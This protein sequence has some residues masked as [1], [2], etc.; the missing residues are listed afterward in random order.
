MDPA[1]RIVASLL[2]PLRSPDGRGIILGPDQALGY[3]AT[4]GLSL[5][6]YR[7][8]SAIA[9]GG[10]NGGSVGSS[11]SSSRRDDKEHCDDDGIRH[12]GTD[13][14]A[15]S[16][17]SLPTFLL[18]FIRAALFRKIQDGDA[19]HRAAYGNNNQNATTSSTSGNGKG[20]KQQQDAGPEMQHRGSCHCGS[21]RFTLCAPR[22]ISAL[23]CGGKIRY[24]HYP[25]TAD[26][27]QLTKGSRHLKMYYVTVNN[28]S[29]DG[30]PTGTTCMAAHTFCGRCGVNLLRAPDSNMDALEVN[31]GCLDKDGYTNVNVDYY[32][33]DDKVGLGAGAPLPHQ[34][35]VDECDEPKPATYCDG[36]EDCTTLDGTHGPIHVDDISTFWPTE[37]DSSSPSGGP[38]IETVDS[39]HN[40]MTPTNI[41]TDHHG[42]M[43]PKGHRGNKGGGLGGGSSALDTPSTSA[44]TMSDVVAPLPPRVVLSHSLQ[45]DMMDCQ[46]SIGSTDYLN[47]GGLGVIGEG[48]PMDRDGGWS[49]GP[50]SLSLRPSPRE[51]SLN[52]DSLKYFMN[53]HM[54]TPPPSSSFNSSGNAGNGRNSSF[55]SSGNR[56]QQAVGN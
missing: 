54:S 10:N 1:A 39:H 23:D 4:L 27:F 47:G 20:G 5:A 17:L 12:N 13:N 50:S 34:W 18:T 6:V 2:R 30:S 28:V 52:R 40:V 44:S 9:R 8:V 49:V 14:Q 31:V 56:R 29:E 45:S 3:A 42:G 38:T 33:A 37:L 26:K 53:R 11:S 19:Y 21:I 51:P 24:P 15:L 46:S 43:M 41:E 7:L 48:A 36:D 32:R 16:L 25:T 35:L 22:N 55:N